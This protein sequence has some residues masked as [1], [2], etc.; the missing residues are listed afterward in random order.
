MNGMNATLCLFLLLGLSRNSEHIA[1][2][3]AHLDAVGYLHYVVL[4]LDV[5]YLAVDAAGSDELCAISY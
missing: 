2:V 3:H 5:L 4:L 1:L